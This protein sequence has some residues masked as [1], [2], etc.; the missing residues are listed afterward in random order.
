MQGN[1]NREI[2]ELKDK[3]LQVTNRL[4]S[5]DHSIG[6]D[7][8]KSHLQQQ[9]L[10][11]SL[12]QREQRIFETEKKITLYTADIPAIHRKD[13][14]SK[15]FINAINSTLKDNTMIPNIFVPRH[16]QILAGRIILTFQSKSIAKQFVSFT[17]RYKKAGRKNLSQFFCI[18]QEDY[19]GNKTIKAAIRTKYN[20]ETTKL[21][22]HQCYVKIKNPQGPLKNYTGAYISTYQVKDPQSKRKRIILNGSISIDEENF[23]INSKSLEELTDFTMEFFNNQRDILDLSAEDGWI[24]YLD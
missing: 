6:Q 12:F 1:H 19:E 10:E 2:K 7:M 23:T 11:N 3:L 15:D 24:K 21:Q 5:G 17:N 13:F 14:T 22:I 8:T 18:L 16:M 20:T 4:D 9:N